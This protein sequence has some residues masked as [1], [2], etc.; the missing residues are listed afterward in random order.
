MKNLNNFW[1]VLSHTYI[2]KVKRKQ[3][4]TSTV[5]TLI[6]ILLMANIVPIIEFFVSL[7]D[8]DTKTVVVVDETNQ[9]GELFVDTFQTM[10]EDTPIKLGEH[11]EKGLKEQVLN[12]EIKGYVLLQLDERGIPQAT[13]K[14]KNL[15]EF[16]TQEELNSTLQQVKMV[17]VAQQMN[18]SGEQL[19]LLN[20]PASFDQEALEEGSKTQEEL[21]QA[22]GLVYILLFVIYFA[23]ILYANMI[24]TEVATEK[25][26]RVMEILISSVSPVTQMFAKII[27]VGLVGLT[28]MIIWLGIG[29]FA[30]QKNVEKMTG[31]FFSVFGFENAS[32][33]TIIYAIV[34]FLLGFFLYA[35]LA[36][37]LGS[38]VSRIE[39]VAQIISP[40]TWLIIIGFLLAMFGLYTPEATFITVT[41]YIPFFTPMIM[42]MRV[43]V[44]NL[45]VWE[46]LLGI[47]VLIVSIILLGNFAAKVYKGGVLMYGASSSLKD[48]KTALQLGKR[49]NS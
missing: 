38:L 9:L 36:A 4:I 1:V 25:A 35:T 10:H 22:R 2:S 32:I 11:D 18:L 14:A 26:S 47:A 7:G 45:P 43:G 40:M 15:S 20:E 19:L 33:S 3:F 31:G 39:D 12:D 23:V 42:F 41:S 27:G 48:I 21:S 13:Y 29:Y 46:P 37:L 34:F 24:A 8:D 28:Q 44:L 5:G 16:G 17:Y 30:L 6:F 49:N